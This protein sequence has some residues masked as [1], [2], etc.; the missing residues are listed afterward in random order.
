MTGEEPNN[1]D[2]ALA[3]I[4]SIN[5][6]CWLRALRLGAKLRQNQL[7]RRLG[8][9]IAWVRE[10][11]RNEA[12]VLSHEFVRWCKACGRKPE[13]VLQWM[14]DIAKGSPVDDLPL[15]SKQKKRRKRL[16]HSRRATSLSSTS[17][18]QHNVA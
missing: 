10:R 15:M 9:R 12:A 11:E 16:S 3:L 1:I 8:V 2:M 7:A 4:L 18:T 14:H 6:G 17:S 5:V 13:E